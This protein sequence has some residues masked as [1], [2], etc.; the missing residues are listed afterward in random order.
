MQKPDKTEKRFRLE[1][2]QIKVYKTKSK[3]LTEHY[4]ITKK[5][6]TLS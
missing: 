3:S 6:T 4:L 5:I 1:K 2:K